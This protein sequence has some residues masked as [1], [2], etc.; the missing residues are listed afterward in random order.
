M[1]DNWDLF[2][3]PEIPM[4]SLEEYREIS[5]WNSDDGLPPSNSTDTEAREKVGLLSKE[6]IRRIRSKYLPEEENKSQTIVLKEVLVSC[7][8]S[9][10]H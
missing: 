7:L 8:V 9:P 5:Q 1:A 10:V 2:S 6:D 3:E 4:I